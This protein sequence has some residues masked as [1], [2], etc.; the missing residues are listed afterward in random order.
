[1]DC[2]HIQIILK[3]KIYYTL[4]FD[5]QNTY[6]VKERQLFLHTKMKGQTGVNVMCL[7]VLHSLLYFTLL[8]KKQKDTSIFKLRPDL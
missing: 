7:T 1:M 3:L 5:N 2:C 4:T 6:Q 8:V